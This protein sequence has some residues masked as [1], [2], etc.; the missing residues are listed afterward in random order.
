MKTQVNKT[1]FAKWAMIL[2]VLPAVLFQVVMGLGPSVTT[3]ILSFTD[4]SGVS[5]VPWRFVGFDNY[6]EFF[7]QQSSRDLLQVIQNTLVFCIGVTVIQNV[8]ALFIALALNSRLIKGKSFFRAVIF[9]PVVLGVLVT[10]LVWLCV[11]NP[12]DGPISQ[13]IG[14]FGLK[15]GFFTQR[16]TALVWVIFTQIWM[17]MGYSMVI[18]LAGLQ[19]IPNELYEAGEIDGTSGAQR[20]RFLTLPLLMPTL[21]VNILLAVIGSLQS[22]QVI[23]LTTGGNNLYT[24]TL[25]ARVV[26]FAF[27]INAGSGAAVMRQGYGA[28]WAMVLFVF[29]LTATLI[30]QKVLRGKEDTSL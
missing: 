4:I 7:V 26:Y 9:L 19:A 18:N 17:A 11:L 3:F 8:I 1:S 6:R 5:G 28:T 30:Y 29:I 21:H 12:M 23:L 14:L 13:L 25:S 10:S 20:L 27:N 2:G 22:F 24:Q 16:S 15:S